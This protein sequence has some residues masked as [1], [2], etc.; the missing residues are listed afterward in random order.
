MPRPAEHIADGSHESVAD[1]LMEKIRGYLAFLE[2]EESARLLTALKEEIEAEISV[3]EGS[4]ARE[5]SLTQA[6]RETSRFD[7][8]AAMHLELNE[9]EMDRFLRV[10]SVPALH[11]NCTEYRDLLAGK[12]LGMVEQEL[13]ER[14]SGP[15]PLPYALVSM[16]SDGREEQTLI[17]DQDYLIVYGD[18]GGEGADAYFKEFSELLVERLAEIGFKKCTG[19]IMPSNPTWRGSLSQWRKKLLA[20]VRYEYADYAKNLMDLIVLS[21]ARYVAGDAVLAQ[22]LIEHIRGLEQDYFQVL[23]GMAKAATEMKLALG[24]LKRFWTEGSGDHK[25]E[26][27]LK[28]LAWAPLVMN[29]RILSIN[30]GIPATN[31]IRRIELLEKERSLSAA[32]AGGLKDAYHV[33][34]KHRILLQI[35]V[36]KGI[37]RDSYYLNPYRLPAD[38]RE[39]IR[40]ALLQIEDLQKMIHT[41]FSIM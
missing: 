11:S 31:T 13:A 30:H 37:N 38:E 2:R 27:N 25:G 12:V 1:G 20:I 40:Q 26:F 9:L 24:F 39:Q 16:G 21:D 28:L 34:T 17:T 6:I 14:G 35:K 15:A 3:A 33:L 29:V 23:W 7:A 32:T 18:G 5:L 19:D 10:Q 22:S 4:L 41:N 8:L 36:I